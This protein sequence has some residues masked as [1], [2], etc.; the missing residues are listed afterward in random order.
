MKTNIQINNSLK[1]VNSKVGDM[2]YVVNFA[3]SGDSLVDARKEKEFIE[4]AS[5][6]GGRV[7]Q[8][9]VVPQSQEG[10]PWWVF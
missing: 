1:Q 2:F 7:V 3:G 9:Y 10:K 6:L 4:V 8:G 5:R